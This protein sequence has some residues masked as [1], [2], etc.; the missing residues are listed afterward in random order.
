MRWPRALRQ[1]IQELRGTIRGQL[2]AIDLGDD[3]HESKTHPRGPHRNW[4]RNGVQHRPG[5]KTSPQRVRRPTTP[6]DPAPPHARTLRIPATRSADRPALLP[7]ER[8]VGS[9]VTVSPPMAAD[10]AERRGLGSARGVDLRIC[11]IGISASWVQKK[12]RICDALGSRT[13]RGNTD[14][15]TA[16]RDGWKAKAIPLPHPSSAAG[17][18]HDGLPRYPERPAQRWRR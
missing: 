18:P 7:A 15:F 3:L 16:E 5:A 9:S 13:S 2:P 4:P 1:L 11:V 6:H 8:C 14:S 10:S 17:E 12:R